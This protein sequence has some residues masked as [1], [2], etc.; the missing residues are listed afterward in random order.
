[1]NAWIP[2]L[3][4]L[5][6]SQTPVQLDLQIRPGLE[7]VYSNAILAE[8]SLT[9]DGAPVADQ[10][11]DF[12]LRQETLGIACSPG[13]LP[14][15]GVDGR[16][17]PLKVRF[18]NGACG[19]D[20]F[21]ASDPDG[22]EYLLEARTAATGTLAAASQAVAVRLHREVVTVQLLPEHSATLGSDLTLV[23][24]LVDPSGDVDEGSLE[25]QGRVPR[26]IEGATLHF[27]LD[28]NDD[29][30]FG[31]ADEALGSATTSASGTA[32]LRFDTTPVAGLPRA[33][34]HRD[35]VRVEFSADERFKFAAGL[36]DLWLQPA[37]VD[38][39]QTLLETT[40]HTA[41]ADGHS[42]ILL[43][44]T[45]R[46][47]FGSTLGPDDDPHT[48]GFV[49]SAGDLQDSVERN[50]ATGQYSQLLRAP[51]QAGAA[52]VRVVVD[53]EE[54]SQVEVMFTDVGCGCSLSASPRQGWVLVF[55]YGLVWRRRS[56]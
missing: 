42:E 8:V 37:S 4:A 10:R 49:T 43:L 36:G 38:A 25:T 34:R 35:A 44:A 50:A 1:M 23:A 41:V 45:L 22:V 7:V 18:V 15:T 28:L 29:G 17:G 56:P 11:V 39:K 33:G 6:S 40:P 48:V 3:A 20:A 21:A 5:L 16:A 47:R 12:F 54:G 51:G 9:A 19:V 13:S 30:D 31:D 55:L 27:Y 52:T 32:S 24:T 53:G 14:A 2:G 46:D 26:P